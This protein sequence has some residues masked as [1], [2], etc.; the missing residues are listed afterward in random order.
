MEM[1]KERKKKKKK[2]SINQPGLFDLNILN[3]NIY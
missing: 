3:N 1:E 2:L